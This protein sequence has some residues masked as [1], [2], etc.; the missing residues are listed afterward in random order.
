MFIICILY[1]YLC[2]PDN[3][4]MINNVKLLCRE[5]DSLTYVWKNIKNTTDI[6]DVIIIVEFMS[7]RTSEIHSILKVLKKKKKC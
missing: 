6:D 7:Y 4:S 3:I 5:F 2:I 1:I